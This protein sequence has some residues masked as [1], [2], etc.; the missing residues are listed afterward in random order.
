MTSD[1]FNEIL[2][3]PKFE[4]DELRF[5]DALT[6]LSRQNKVVSCEFDA[7][8]YDCGNKL[9]YTKCLIDFALE[10]KDIA[11]KLKE[12]LKERSE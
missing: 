10:D 12:Y 4:N 3:C 1:I 6:S 7:R 5:T 8:Y 9:E 11:P 2:K